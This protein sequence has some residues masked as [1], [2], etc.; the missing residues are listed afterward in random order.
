MAVRGEMLSFEL[1][2]I[3]GLCDLTFLNE[4]LCS[5]SQSCYFSL[6][7]LE[8]EQSYSKDFINIFVALSHCKSPTVTSFVTDRL[9]LHKGIVVGS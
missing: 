1:R 3:H 7:P 6:Y 8:T 5:G 9:A 2:L 4:S